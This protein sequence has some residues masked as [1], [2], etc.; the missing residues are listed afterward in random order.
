MKT[1]GIITGDVINS[2]RIDAVAREALYSEIQSFL[3]T[4]K[5]RGWI[6]KVE[7]SGGDSFQCEAAEIKYVL[8]IALMIKCFVKTKTQANK[9]NR[10]NDNNSINNSLRFAGV[11]VAVGIGTADFIKRKLSESDGE[12]F[13]LA[14]EGLAELKTNFS[15]L[16][17]EA[18]DKKLTKEIRPLILLLDALIQKYFGGQAEVILN[19][20]QN[21]KE[22]EVAN[23]MS[24]SQPGVNQAARSAKWYAVET[25]VKHIENKLIETY[26]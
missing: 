2:R 23:I 8:R 7:Q 26:E 25:A 9:F 10:I 6:K 15:E 22:D 18:N 20:L 3:K 4:L 19:K 16:A 21:K 1:Y 13:I 24:I 14:S 11:R 5:E 17:L 12:A